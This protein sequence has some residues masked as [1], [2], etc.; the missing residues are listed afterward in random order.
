M[1]ARGI[2]VKE[3]KPLVLTQRSSKPP[4]KECF[5][6]IQEMVSEYW[7][8][9][10]MRPWGSLPVYSGLVM[11]ARDDQERL[12]VDLGHRIHAAGH[13]PERIETIVGRMIPMRTG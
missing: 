12:V 4:T 5:P 9:G 10:V 7:Y 13:F 11:P 1:F 3:L 8:T 2:T 6:F